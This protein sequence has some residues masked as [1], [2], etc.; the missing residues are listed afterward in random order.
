MK[1]SIILFIIISSHLHLFGQHVAI[2]NTKENTVYFGIATPLDVVVENM[3]CDSFFLSTDNGR[4]DGESCNFQFFP[5]HIGKANIFVKKIT[6]ND[7]IV[8]SKAFFKVTSLPKPTAYIAG[9]RGGRI[10]K[11]NL[12]A[13]TGVYAQLDNFDFDISLH[14]SSYSVIVI[15]NQQCIFVT[16][17]EGGKF[18]DIM[19]IEF[20][21]L[22]KEDIVYFLDIVVRWR[23]GREDDVNSIKFIIQ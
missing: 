3:S 5:A 18:S 15:R 6:E 23:E 2:S 19:K 14:I 21:R 12:A 1:R 7:T 11:N 13:Q 4:V 10:S 22:E 8:L 16:N 17:I 9:M 20:A